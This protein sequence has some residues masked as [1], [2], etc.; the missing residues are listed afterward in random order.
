[1]G[2]LIWSAMGGGGFAQWMKGGWPVGKYGDVFF[3][4]SKMRNDF[5]FILFIFFFYLYFM[6]I[7]LI[8]EF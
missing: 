8:Q 4:K 1:V 3:K 7:F 5:Y 2:G 6:I